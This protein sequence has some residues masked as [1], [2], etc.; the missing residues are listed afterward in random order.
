MR[1]SVPQFIEHEA[2][3]VGP[4][5]FKQ[6]LYIGSAGVIGFV[7]YHSLPRP[8]FLPIVI[9]L[10][11]GSFALAFVKING[12]P[13]PK[14]IANFFKFVLSSRI[15]LWQKDEE[16]TGAQRKTKIETFEKKL[17]IKEELTKESQLRKISTKI[18]T[19]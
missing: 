2:K 16:K 19:N 9:I 5:T 3:I 17:S 10:G 14:A 4:L 12:M 13:L 15:Y 18:D 1:F 7:F 8:V 11:L 6:F